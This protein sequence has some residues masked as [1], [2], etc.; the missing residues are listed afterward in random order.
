M[1]PSQDSQYTS[2]YSQ[3]LIRPLRSQSSIEPPM[4]VVLPRPRPITKSLS[5]EVAPALTGTEVLTA[6]QKRARYRAEGSAG[7]RR[8]SA[9]GGRR[10]GLVKSLSEGSGSSRLLVQDERIAQLAKRRESNKNNKFVEE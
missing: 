8:R 4:T 1:Y 6:D 3:L 10:A 5:F 2:S 9:M 7:G